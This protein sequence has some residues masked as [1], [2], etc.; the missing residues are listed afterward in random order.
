MQLDRFEFDDP[1]P[2]DDASEY[3]PPVL[4]IPSVIDVE[5]TSKCEY[6][7]PGC[8]GTKPNEAEVELN[9]EQWLEL[10]EKWDEIADD[11][12][13]R[14][15]LTGGEPLL[16]K[17][18]HE[19]TSCLKKSGRDITLSTTGLDRYHQ[20]PRI[21]DDLTSI[22][23]PIDGASG[24]INSRWRSHYQIQ[25]GGLEIAV[26]ALKFAQKVKPDLNISVRTLI[27]PSNIEHVNEIPRYLEKQGLDI[28]KIRWL[29]YELNRGEGPSR[30]YGI[31]RRRLVSSRAI[32][33]YKDGESEF[34]ESIESS[35]KNLKEI[36]VRTIGNLANRYFII[37]PYG[38]TR[39]VVASDET[40]GYLEEVE[41]G[42]MYTEF[43]NTIELLNQDIA[44]L[45]LFSA[46]AANSPA[47]FYSQ[48]D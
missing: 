7:C 15:I 46:A 11:W 18:L 17:N 13:S 25:D 23:I 27:H 38:E 22:G 10:F 33:N 44:R 2:P 28:S 20:L 26:N 19:I 14:V 32:A 3:I 41:Y 39:A 47:Y 24:E 40:D 48:I 35:G 37:N 34:Y 4:Y 1:T 9:N 43:E 5:I 6:Q 45:G 29:L 16:R 8:W 31:S 36:T 30:P 21:L 12:V 42:N